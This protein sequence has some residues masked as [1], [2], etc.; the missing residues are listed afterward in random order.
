MIVH[1]F[2]R[3][4]ISQSVSK[5]EVDRYLGKQCQLHLLYVRRIH[6]NF[7]KQQFRLDAILTDV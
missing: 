1:K 6:G 7:H 3:Y 5:E 2:V 4:I